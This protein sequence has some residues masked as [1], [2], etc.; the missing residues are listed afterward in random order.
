MG[1]PFSAVPTAYRV[2]ADNGRWFTNDTSDGFGTG[3]AFHID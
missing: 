3:N 2:F 1:S